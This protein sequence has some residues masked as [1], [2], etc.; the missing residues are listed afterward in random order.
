MRFF[1]RNNGD[2][3]RLGRFDWNIASPLFGKCYVDIQTPFGSNNT[4]E[5]PHGETRSY[6][7]QW[8]KERGFVEIEGKPVISASGFPIDG[9]ISL[10]DFS[11]WEAGV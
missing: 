6:C 8:L 1:K 5:V 10:V 3:A 11:K 7:E 4:D 2:Y 9:N